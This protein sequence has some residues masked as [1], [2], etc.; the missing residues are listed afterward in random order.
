MH[1]KTISI[2]AALAMLSV[3]SLVGCASSI[4]IDSLPTATGNPARIRRDTSSPVSTSI[5]SIDGF[6]LSESHD[7]A[8]N[9]GL[10]WIS[11]PAGTHR[12]EVRG[13]ES[14]LSSQDAQ[15][16]TKSGTA[17]M[18]FQTGE[19]TILTS[20]GGRLRAHYNGWKSDTTKTIE[21]SLAAGTHYEVFASALDSLLLGDSIVVLNDS[22][23]KAWVEEVK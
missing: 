9:T 20:G 17:E 7:Q 3:S 5:R 1:R 12:I 13:H 22:K 18:N 2:Y 19:T 4:T 11:L 8:V 6:V 16:L 21:V 23:W 14:W 10:K 15:L